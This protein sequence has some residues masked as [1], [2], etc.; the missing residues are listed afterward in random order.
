MCSSD[1]VYDFEF[2]QVVSGGIAIDSI[3]DELRLKQEPHILVGGEVLDIDGLCGGY[4]L[5]F[6]FCCG[7]K[8]GEVLCNIK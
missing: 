3:T 7:L 6:A 1:L 4:N 8:I 5:M 2:A